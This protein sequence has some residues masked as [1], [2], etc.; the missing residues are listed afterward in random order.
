MRSLGWAEF[1]KVEMRDGRK[2]LAV[3]YWM[4]G[5]QFIDHFPVTHVRSGDPH[6]PDSPYWPPIVSNYHRMVAP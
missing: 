6:N 5:P 4:Y 2:T 3:S 1:L